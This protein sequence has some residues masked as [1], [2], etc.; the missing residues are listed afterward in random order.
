VLNALALGLF[1][2]VGAS[3]ATTFG[4][5]FV[6]AVLI[7][8]LSAVGGGM[9]VSVLQ[10]EVPRILLAGAPNAL[11]AVWGATAYLIVA[12]FSPAAASFA[13]IA[14]VLIARRS[15]SGSASRP[16]RRT[17]AARRL[18]VRSTQPAQRA[19]VSV[20]D[21]RARSIT[22]RAT[23]ATFAAV[24]P[25]WAKSSL[26]R[27]GRTEARHRDDL[28]TLADD[29][30]PALRD[31]G[32]DRDPRRDAAGS[33]ASRTAAS[34]LRKRVGDGIDTTRTSTPSR[35]SSSAAA[36][37]T[38][39]SDPVPI[40]TTSGVAPSSASRTTH[41][42]CSTASSG[43][44][45]TARLGEVRD[46]L[47]RER[48]DGRPL[49]LEREPPRERRLRHRPQDAGPRRQGWRAARRGARPAGASARPR[50]A[51]SSRASSRRRP[52]GA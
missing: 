13:G 49:A 14:T 22:R 12:R 2:V 24:K 35:A 38:P 41:A 40:S 52:A 18:S 26:G 32:L 43:T 28:A 47:A 25:K 1:A 20:P 33:T 29:A 5:P 39:T 7:G 15:R 4:L 17:D 3:Y 48:D 31:P 21:Q 51:R 42:P 36:R 16:A 37:H 27:R 34:A 50:R 19:V 10:G 8:T 23:R 11:L 44:G 6:S 46:A 9:L 45:R 30:L